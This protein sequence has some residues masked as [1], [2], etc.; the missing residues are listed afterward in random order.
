MRTLISKNTYT[1][2]SIEYKFEW[3]YRETVM[4]AIRA[5]MTNGYAEESIDT[6][7]SILSYLKASSGLLDSSGTH[8]YSRDRF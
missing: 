5:T 7:V 2:N 8:T 1:C 4:A 3:R 6:R